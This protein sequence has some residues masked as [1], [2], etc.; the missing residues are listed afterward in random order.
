[1]NEIYD[2]IF[3]MILNSFPKELS[4][5]V[6]A[7]I[8]IIPYEKFTSRILLRKIKINILL[9]G[10]KINIPYRIYFD[11]PKDIIELN[12]NQEII[13][14]CLYSRHHNGFIRQKCIEKL[15]ENKN[16][17]ITPFFVQLFG[18]YI[19]KMMEIFN[20]YLNKNMDNC[21]KFFSEN[22]NYWKKIESKVSSYWDAYYRKECPKYNKYLGK[23]IINKI[24]YGMKSNVVRPN[25]A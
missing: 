2:E 10:E 25:F 3:E 15:L 20:V 9:N 17:W 5:D 23:E 18:E 8:N 1:M 14:N 13:L 7:V 11:E 21:I 6:N 22:N 16:Y 24:K 12:S 19:Y 4:Q